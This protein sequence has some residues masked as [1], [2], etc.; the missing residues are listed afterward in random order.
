MNNKKTVLFLPIFTLLLSSCSASGKHY[1]CKEYVA[2]TLKFKEDF[3]ILQ[4]TDVHLGNKDI[5]EKHFDFMSKTINEA[6]ADL[7]VVTGDVFTFADKNT[8][9]SVF[10]FFDSFDTPW[11]M[12]WGNHDEQTYYD[13]DWMTG[14]LNNY[15]SNCIFK[16]LQDDDVYGNAN[17]VINLT[18]DGTATSAVKQQLIIMDSN[19]YCY[20][21]FS[22]YDAIHEDQVKWYE[23]MVNYTTAQYSGTVV[24]SLA[25]FHI[26]FV[27]FQDAYKKAKEGTDPK[28]KFVEGVGK[29][30]LLNEDICSP[31]FNYGEGLY[32]SI[33]KLGST[34]GVFVGHDHINTCCVDDDG[35]YLCYGIK[36]TT[37]IYYDEELMGGQVVSMDSTN[38]ISIERYFHTYDE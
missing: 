21:A 19:R 9:K 24:P 23:D 2:G 16:D 25:F 32:K 6:H 30:D 38:K 37:R 33:K 1:E 34:K 4:M 14:Y 12:T 13:I 5:L 18:E 3:R 7:I 29:A 11:T 36:A 8:A 35:L 15:G 31:S 26:P 20:K 27:E 10:K 28:V 22:G 17:F